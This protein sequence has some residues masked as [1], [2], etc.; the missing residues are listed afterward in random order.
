MLFSAQQTPTGP[1][2]RW[3]FRPSAVP[4]TQGSLK[5]RLSTRTSAEI[6][7]NHPDSLRVRWQIVFAPVP[8][9][10][11]PTVGYVGGVH[12]YE[13]HAVEGAVEDDGWPEDGV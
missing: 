11:A 13:P 8:N 9:L 4:G 1:S 3:R 2:Q 12:A 6:R 7:F 10:H 5:R